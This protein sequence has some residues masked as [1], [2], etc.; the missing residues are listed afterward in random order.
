MTKNFLPFS[1]S[2][3]RNFDS[4]IVISLDFIVFTLFMLLSNDNCWFI[5]IIY[6]IFLLLFI[7]LAL[8]TMN[9]LS[10]KCKERIYW[11]YGDDNGNCDRRVMYKSFLSVLFQCLWVVFLRRFLTFWD[12]RAPSGEAQSFCCSPQS[13]SCTTWTD[14]KKKT[15]DKNR[16]WDDK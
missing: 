6:D 2:W 10:N 9:L 11:Q 8:E 3:H 5:L 16:L 14:K 4:Y 7:F 13:R 1:S 15:R 12:V